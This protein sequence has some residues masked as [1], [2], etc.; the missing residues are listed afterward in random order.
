[1]QL[2]FSTTTIRAPKVEYFL[3]VL[4]VLSFLRDTPV[5]FERSP[6]TSFHFDTGNP[7]LLVAEECFPLSF[8]GVMRQDTNPTF[9]LNWGPLAKPVLSLRSRCHPYRAQ[10]H[11]NSNEAPR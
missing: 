10:Q 2:V 3:L 9:P 6:Q 8:E 7:G 5:P 11:E 1:M 4:Q